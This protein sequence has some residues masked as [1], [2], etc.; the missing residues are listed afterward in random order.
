VEGD[1]CSTALEER[2]VEMILQIPGGMGGHRVR[3]ARGVDEGKRARATSLFLKTARVGGQPRR[4]S[5]NRPSTSPPLPMEYAQ[6]NPQ[7]PRFS[8]LSSSSLSSA[9]H[10]SPNS[11]RFSL[12]NTPSINTTLGTPRPNLRPNIYDRHLNKTRA[13]EVSASSFAYLFS[14]VVQYTQKRVSGINDL[15]RR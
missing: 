7:N 5:Y 13:A 10:L 6:G 8:V 14:E 11:S 1:I 4:T 12:P 15:E 3:G 9:E 2:G